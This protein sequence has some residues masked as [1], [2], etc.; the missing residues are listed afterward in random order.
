MTDIIKRQ[1]INYD[2]LQHRFDACRHMHD[3]GCKEDAEAML[4]TL[5]ENILETIND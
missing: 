2:A 1:E 5:A 3:S 4:E